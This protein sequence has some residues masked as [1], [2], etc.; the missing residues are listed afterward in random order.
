MKTTMFKRS[1]SGFKILFAMFV[2]LTAL[3]ST[4]FCSNVN[5]SESSSSESEVISN[6][7]G[8]SIRQI[9][10]DLFDRMKAGNT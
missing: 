10:D 5:A 3:G 9:S 8:F 6:R 2:L 4:N 1:H 7:E